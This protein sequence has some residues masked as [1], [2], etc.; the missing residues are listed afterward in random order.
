MEHD[1]GGEELALLP[2]GQGEGGGDLM[3]A[4]IDEDIFLGIVVGGGFGQSGG[5]Y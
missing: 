5:G 4:G 2:Y 1:H 3:V